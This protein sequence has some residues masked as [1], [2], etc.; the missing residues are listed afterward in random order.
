L[1]NELLVL[2]RGLAAAGFSIVPR[3]PN[4]QSPGKSAALHVRLDASGMPVESTFLPENRVDSLWTLRK[5]SHNSF[6]YIQ[7][8]QPLLSVPKDRNWHSNWSE[9]WK[10]L[11]LGEK[12]QELRNLIQQFPVADADWDKWPGPGLKT[13]LATRIA[14]LSKAGTETR[15]VTALIERFL[16]A[17]EQSASF[18]RT[19][20]ER[21]LHDLADADAEFLA[22]ICMALVGKKGSKDK[23]VGAPL[24]LDVARHEFA[25]DMLSKDQAG[26]I[27]AA[28]ASSAVT[29][30]DA[31]CDLTGAARPLHIGP[32]PRPKL[33][34]LGSPFL[35]VKNRDIPAAYRYGI[36]G[37]RAI[38]V[39]AHFVQRLAGALEAI[40]AK[41]L[42]GKTWRSIPSE[43]PKK[44]DLLLAFVDRALEAPTADVVAGREW[45]EEEPNGESSPAANRAAFLQRTKRLVDA[46]RAK[47]GD[48]FRQTSVTF[49]ILRKVDE[50]NAKTILYR[51]STVGKLYDAAVDWSRA[52]DNLPDW[53]TFPVPTKSKSM[54]DG[55]PPHIAPLQLPRLTRRLFLKNGTERAKKEPVG[56]SAQEAFSLF[57]DDGDARSIAAGMLSLLLDRQS[58]LLS[59]AAEALRK[60]AGKVKFDSAL[61]FDRIAALD[62]VAAIGVSLAK[63]GRHKE[64]YMNDAAFKLG[65]LLAV[66]DVVHV[67]YC[68]DMRGGDIPPTLL[69]N[70]VLATAQSDPVKALSLLCRR[71]KP[72]G[73]WA[74]RPSV[75][76]EANKFKDS[77]D[78]EQQNR[79]WVVLKA[80]SQARRVSELAQELHDR[81]PL[82]TDDQIRA[83]LLLGYLTGLPTNEKA[84]GE[85][86]PPK[87]GN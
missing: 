59:G 44:S 83:E 82:H 72:Y 85:V 71:W 47:V 57:L 23:V 32:F 4:V 11:S 17:T 33:H 9:K 20:D 19:L 56:I 51:A 43:K 1:L 67:G 21:L 65:Q 7:M 36:F 40:T 29:R 22:R 28:L 58:Q 18:I 87:G 2:E 54:K 45:E 64:V 73:A 12:R 3:H 39:D 76:T 13:Y 84:N 79:G 8:K 14:V 41:H 42:E 27:A 75:W 50:G 31:V 78:K 60:D 62:S 35:F 30:N 81:L 5:G 38:G 66:A 6:P 49:C 37:D 16:R 25:D 46:I 68:M 53:L 15:S 61:K 24:Y 69:G 70:S 74:K 55:R 10:R 26:R 86:K 63:L 34:V 52:H 77:S 48:D 80:L